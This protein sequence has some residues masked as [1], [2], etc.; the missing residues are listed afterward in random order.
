MPPAPRLPALLTG[1]ANRATSPAAARQLHAQLLLRGLPLPARAAVTLL[2]A[3]SSSP[4]Y[5]RAI[6]DSVPAASANVYLW[7]ATISSYAKHASSPALAAEAF[8]LFR[9]MLRSGPPPNAFT[10]SSVLKSLS[11]LREVHEVCQAHGFMMKAGLGSSVHAGSALLDS[12]GNL[13]RVEDAR[14][15]FDE[16]PARNVVVGNA[17]VACYARA[18]DVEA[19]QEMFDGMEERD[20]IS[21]NTLMSGRLRQGDAGVAR[22]LFDQMPQ[23]NVNSWNMMITACSQAG[24]WADSVGVFNRMRLTSFQPDAA[25][26]AVLMSACAQLGSL[27]VA[28]QVHGLLH[29]GCVEMNCHVQNSLIDM[30]AKCGCISEARFLFGETR[31]KDVV[32]YNVMVTALAQH[33]H[34]KDSLKLFNDMIDEGLQ[35]DAVTFL[36]VLSACAHAGLVYDGKHYFESMGTTYAIQKSA[37]H[38]ACMVDLYGRAGLI[39]EAHCFVKMMPVKPHAGVW[40]ALLSACRKHCNI[41]VGEVAARE[42]IMIEPMN[43]GNYVLLANTLA[44]SQRWDAVEDVRRLMRGNVIEKDIGLSWVEVDTVVHEFLTGDFSHPSFNQIYNILE[45]L[46]LQPT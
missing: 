18:G 34:G 8:G 5:A 21:W 19:A 16:M 12:Y 6:F 23:R 13:G 35:P 36:G 11:T 22:C 42:L 38:Y 43:A 27:S 45:H 4:R 25:T 44:R 41:D 31:P 30:F 17:M 7:T 15:V 2:N 1:L 10:V 39:E 26:M 20:L 33:G 9:L 24:L 14:R 46:Y 3:S 32:S 40:G 29:K 28:R 37:D